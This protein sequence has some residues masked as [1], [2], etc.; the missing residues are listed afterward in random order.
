MPKFNT[1]RADERSAEV[2]AATPQPAT[3]EGGPVK[4]DDTGKPSFISEGVRAELE[5]YGVATDVNGRRIVGTGTDDA[6]YEDESAVKVPADGD[7]AK[8]SDRAGQVG[9]TTA[10]N[11]RIK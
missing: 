1:D 11:E 9:A 5:T 8:A 7:Q 2:K 10:T 6:R 3:A 4:Q